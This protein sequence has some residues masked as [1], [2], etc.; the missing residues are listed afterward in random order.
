[1]KT[2]LQI[3]TVLNKGS[4]GRIV[5]GI[6]EVLQ[7]NGWE[8]YIA[9]ARYGRSDN[10]RL[11]KIGNQVGV[12]SHV[13]GTRLT[14]RHGLYSTKA[15]L[16]LIKQISSINP[17]VIH[18]HN[19]HGYYIN[20]RVLFQY[21]SKINI[22]IVWTLHDCWPFT[23]HCVYFD[24]CRCDKWKVCCKDCPQ[25]NTYPKAFIDRAEQNFLDKKKAF[26]LPDKILFVP[27]SEWLNELLK[28]SFLKKYPSVV[29]RNGINIESFIPNPNL[30]FN[31]LEGK[32]IIL[33]VANVWEKRKGFLDFIKLAHFLS[34]DFVI[35]LIGLN[36]KQ[37]RKC[38]PNIIGISHTGSISELAS[39]YNRA[40]V[41]LNLTYEDNY[42]TTNLESIVCG[43]PVITYNT[44]GSP[45][46][47]FP[48]NGYVVDK[49]DINAVL[50][51]IDKIRN[52][53]MEEKSVLINYAKN[54]FNQNICFREYLKIYE[55]LI[56]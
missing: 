17:D 27:V 33:G 14:D 41:F 7:D 50:R 15:T 4:V 24:T 13:L 52:G 3:N 2:I 19:L 20:Y 55:S 11:I 5:Q 54:H 46:S 16:N 9:Y 28:E 29:I 32:F 44:G 40:D 31:E 6:G 45:E 30:H 53:E 18:I 36:K 49:G 21:L 1:M 38:P 12:Y 51:C 35:I 42:P 23:G 8:S 48:N 56:G 22:P 47:I 39:Y 34:D 10:F 37:M 43:T 26:T 25:I